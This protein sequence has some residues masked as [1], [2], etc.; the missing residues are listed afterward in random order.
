M[1]DSD[2]DDDDD[3][4]NMCSIAS[5]KHH[6]IS[7]HYSEARLNLIVGCNEI[8]VTYMHTILTP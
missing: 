7:S 1:D 8:Y 3:D 5:H 6:F 4:D 2:D